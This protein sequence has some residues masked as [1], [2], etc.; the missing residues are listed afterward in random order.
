[1][2]VTLVSMTWRISSKSW[3]R[4]PLP[5][6]AAGVGQQ[7]LD[8]A[9]ARSRRTACR[10]L[11][12]W[13]DRPRRP[14]PR[15]PARGVLRARRRWRARRRRRPDRSRSR[16]S[17]WRELVADAGRGAGDDGEGADC[18]CHWSSPFPILTTIWRDEKVVST[19]GTGLRRL[20]TERHFSCRANNV[21]PRYRPPRPLWPC[22]R[23]RLAARVDKSTFS[24][25]SSDLHLN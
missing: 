22:W 4:K 21:L 5:K 11:R 16:R 10:R 19:A 3:S 18:C 1:M 24:V 2:P 8:G 17:T 7:R 23:R 12:A 15:R 6:P 9:A 25:S 20:R 14:R 13:R